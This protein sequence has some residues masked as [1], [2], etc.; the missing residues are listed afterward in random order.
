MWH[1]GH[2]TGLYAV[3]D[4]CWINDTYQPT[5][6][7]LHACVHL[8]HNWTV[9]NTGVHTHVALKSTLNWGR[10]L[11]LWSPTHTALAIML[12]IQPSGLCRGR[13]TKWQ[14][15]LRS[16]REQKYI[17]TPPT[18]PLSQSLSHLLIHSVTHSLSHSHAYIQQ[19][20][21]AMHTHTHAH[22]HFHN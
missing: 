13:T 10:Q 9:V 4:V 3:C 18:H 21:D 12:Y 20:R 1:T 19:W 14:S 2:Y 6:L 17:P 22:T 8:Q 11:T 5:T 15:G 16:F 7:T